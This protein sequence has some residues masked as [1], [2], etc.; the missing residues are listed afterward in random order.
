M[1]EDFYAQYS[2]F[3]KILALSYST[4]SVKYLVPSVAVRS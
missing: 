4:I 3:K 1:L 2:S